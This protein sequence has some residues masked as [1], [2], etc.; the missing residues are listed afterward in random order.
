ML[1]TLLPGLTKSYSRIRRTNI[2]TVSA[3]DML[4][5]LSRNSVALR[6]DQYTYIRVHSRPF[7]DNN[8]ILPWMM[9]FD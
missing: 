1:L 7:A 3:R 4:T 5:N 9:P 8:R 6:R 2:A